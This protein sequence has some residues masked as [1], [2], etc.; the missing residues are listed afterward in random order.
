M[1]DMGDDFRALREEGKERRERNRE[2]GPVVLQREGISYVSHNAGAH[3][4]VESR[5]D[6]WPGTGLFIDRITRLQHRGVRALVQRVKD[7][8]P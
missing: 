8:R 1:S 4:V 6:Y 5:F 7:T 3:L 2:H